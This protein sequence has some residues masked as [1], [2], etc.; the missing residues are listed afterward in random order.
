MRVYAPEVCGQAH[1]RINLKN[2][3]E[4]TSKMISASTPALASRAMACH[5]CHGPDDLS[6]VRRTDTHY[7]DTQKKVVAVLKQMNN[8]Q[9]QVFAKHLN[10]ISV[11]S[12]G[13]F[14]TFTPVD[15]FVFER[16]H[17]FRAE[18]EN[19]FVFRRLN[20]KIHIFGCLAGL[21]MKQ[22]FFHGFH[23]FHGN[24]FL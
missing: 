1:L 24:D 14:L 15:Q 5:I 3:F 6:V 4:T 9:M 11:Q 10:V 13:N 18:A 23:F 2:I 17:S 7:S 16:G 8:R 21:Q 19:E 12:Q 20:F 22:N